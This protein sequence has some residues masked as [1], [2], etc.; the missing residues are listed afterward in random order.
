MHISRLG[1]YDTKRLRE[2]RAGNKNVNGIARVKPQSRV[3]PQYG[4]VAV[5]VLLALRLFAGFSRAAEPQHDEILVSAAISLKEA[6]DEIGDLYTRRTGNRVTFTFG[7]SGE[8]ERQIEAGAPVDVFASAGQR[9]MDQLQ[10]KNLLE[11]GARADFA[12][13]ALVLIVPADS[14]LHL[15]SISDLT[16]ADIR[17]IAIGN[18]KTV[19]AG[20]YA[21]EL[22]DRMNLQSQL[23][24]RLVLAENVSQVLDYVVRGEVDAGIVYVTDVQVA[25]GKVVVAAR[26]PQEDYSPILYPMAVVRGGSHAAA[27]KAFE[28]LVLSPE[29]AQ[30]LTKHGFLAVK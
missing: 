29:G 4:F 16:L 25:A 30:I 26:A 20:V 11:P 12:R 27:A 14:K 13:N 28:N 23:E 6:F 8:L 15:R 18:P 17:K 22:I 21:S 2:P 5:A 10:A 19:P 24:S 9:E 1:V 3:K 7:A